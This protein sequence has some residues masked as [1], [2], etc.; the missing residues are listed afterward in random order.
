MN[1]KNRITV[2]V[3]V[4]VL[5]IAPVL[6][7][8]TAAKP[9]SGCDQDCN[10]ALFDGIDN[11]NTLHYIDEGVYADCISLAQR[12]WALCK[13][14]CGIGGILGLHRRQPKSAT[15]IR[16]FVRLSE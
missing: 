6:T 12:N 15:D 10:Q 13:T 8:T 5:L 11:C 7:S 16:G 4:L 1:I 9:Q 2:F 3:A 14:F